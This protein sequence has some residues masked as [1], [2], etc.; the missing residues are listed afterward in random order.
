MAYYPDPDSS[1]YLH[2]D[3]P[4]E[5]IFTEMVMYKEVHNNPSWAAALTALMAHICMI[6]E[7]NGLT[8]WE[9]DT[10]ADVI[11]IFNLI[12]TDGSAGDAAYAIGLSDIVS[13]KGVMAI[14]SQTDQT[15]AKARRVLVE[16]FYSC[17][18]KLERAPF[19]PMLKKEP[20]KV[21]KLEEGK[22]R[23]IMMMTYALS[24]VVTS[25][26]LWIKDDQLWTLDDVVRLPG[27]RVNSGMGRSIPI[28]LKAG[29]TG[30][31]V[32]ADVSGLGS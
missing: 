7:R 24:A 6:A 30:A 12:A 25:A 1:R 9:P 29:F 23:S 32:S 16:S 17:R 22:T 2:I 31:S 5:S 21:S 20:Y 10:P 26:Y 15:G 8:R 18:D 19:I 14:A 28:A 4:P 27:S 11:R 13:K 3:L